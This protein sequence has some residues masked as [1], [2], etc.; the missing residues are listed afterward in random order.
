[1]GSVAEVVS[2][3]ATQVVT[4]TQS[5]KKKWVCRYCGRE[6]D[7]Q[8][9]CAAHE[10]F[11]KQKHK[12]KKTQSPTDDGTT[13]FDEKSKINETEMIPKKVYLLPSTLVYY[14]WMKNQGYE[15]SLSDFLNDCVHDLFEEFLGITI[16]VISKRAFRGD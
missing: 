13:L 10:R 14:E 8:Q 11:C 2:T 15:G 16:G 7:T 5:E 12:E 6:F 9:A 1:M 4:Q 3:G